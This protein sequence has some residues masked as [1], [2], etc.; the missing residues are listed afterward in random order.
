[1][2]LIESKSIEIRYGEPEV[3]QS[4]IIYQY[5]DEDGEVFWTGSCIT[6]PNWFSDRDVSDFTTIK[7]Y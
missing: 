1:M 6:D 5:E 4:F 7:P 2:N 3:T